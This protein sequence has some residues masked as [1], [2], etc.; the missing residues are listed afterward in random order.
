MKKILERI[1][2]FFRRLTSIFRS[3]PKEY[4]VVPTTT[5]TFTTPMPKPKEEVKTPAKKFVE[6]KVNKKHWTP[7]RAQRAWLRKQ[8]KHPLHKDHFGTYSPMP[9]LVG[10]RDK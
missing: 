5:T 8:G 1:R 9:R 2:L 3:A 10:D 4:V 7:K 6:E